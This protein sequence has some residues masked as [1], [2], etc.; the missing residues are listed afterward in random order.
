MNGCVP[1]QPRRRIQPNHGILGSL[2]RQHA[3]NND[4]M[5]KEEVD[6]ATKLV[7]R[8]GTTR[9]RPIVVPHT[10]AAC[11]YQLFPSPLPQLK[12]LDPGTHRTARLLSGH[13]SA[14]PND[15]FASASVTATELAVARLRAAAVGG[16]ALDH[17]PVLPLGGK[18]SSYARKCG[19]RGG[20]MHGSS[21]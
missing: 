9:M 11:A 7:W 8:A 12:H 13:L 20:G 3:R 15:D 18:P 14:A 4:R 19:A 2:L 10:F 16:E 17:I 21:L 6:K 5:D 1:P